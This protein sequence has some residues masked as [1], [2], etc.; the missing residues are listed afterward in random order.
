MN[1]NHLDTENQLQ[2][3][4]CNF[5]DVEQVTPSASIEIKIIKMVEQDLYP[6]QWLVFIKFFFIESFAGGATL[7]ICPQF[8]LGFGDHNTFFHSL[9][10]TLAPFF[11]YITCGFFFVF[12][13][14]AVSGLLFSYDEI[15]SI[16]RS[17]YIYHILYSFIA[18][19]IFFNLGAEI[20]LLSSTA[21]LLGSIIGNLFGF[22]LVSRTRIALFV[23]H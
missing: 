19:L 6:S 15:R 2:K 9:H 1:Y 17:K 20:L 13:G 4:F 5:V 14:A 10:E 8:G 7:F 11:F 18:Y 23:P 3:E 12:L 22:E 21:W 16:K